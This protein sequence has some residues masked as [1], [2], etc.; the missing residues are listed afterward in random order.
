[1]IVV[2]M[3]G[4]KI[5]TLDNPGWDVAFNFLHSDY[6]SDYWPIFKEKKLIHYLPDGPDDANPNWC[7]SMGDKT[8]FIGSGG[9]LYLGVLL[10]VFKQWH[11]KLPI[12]PGILPVPLNLEHPN[13]MDNLE[14]LQWYYFDLCNGDWEH[15]YG[16]EI[17]TTEEG[18]HVNIDLNDIEYEDHIFAEVHGQGYRCWVEDKSFRGAGDPQSLDAIIGEFRAWITSLNKMVG[19]LEKPIGDKRLDPWACE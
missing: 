8:K 9:P 13:D 18:W 5:G 2:H 7:F 19:Y 10:N 4:L 16:M 14:W 17:S 3:L 15:T 12:D 11:Q 6:E 1:M